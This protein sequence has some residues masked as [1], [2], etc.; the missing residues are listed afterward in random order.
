ME[1]AVAGGTYT[2]GVLASIMGWGLAG[3]LP[4][5]LVAALGTKRLSVRLEVVTD[6]LRDL[7]H[8]CIAFMRLV[9]ALPPCVQRPP[10][11]NILVLASAAPRALQ[12]RGPR[13]ALI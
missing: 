12:K 6:G 9:P 11:C 2:L 3:Q 5:A 7:W 1:I 13:P 10:S 8:E 4:V